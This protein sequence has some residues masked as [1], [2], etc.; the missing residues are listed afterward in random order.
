M[1]YFDDRMKEHCAKLFHDQLE[2]D[3]TLFIGHS[4]TL[5]NTAVPFQAM[6]IPQAFAYTKA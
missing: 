3:G 6:P 4:E 2:D 1:I 5:R